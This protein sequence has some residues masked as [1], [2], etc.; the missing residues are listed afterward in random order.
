MLLLPPPPLRLRRRHRPLPVFIPCAGSNTCRVLD[1]HIY[2]GKHFKDGARVIDCSTLNL[3]ILGPPDLSGF[4]AQEIASLRLN[5]ILT[6]PVTDPATG[7]TT[8]HLEEYGSISAPS[9]PMDLYYGTKRRQLKIRSWR[10]SV[11]SSLSLDF[12]KTITAESQD[13]HLPAIVAADG[14]IPAGPSFSRSSSPRP[15]SIQERQ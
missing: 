3:L 14:P 8:T 2:K 11:F 5:P 1:S 4:G 9:Q 6:I 15:M 10:Y 7:V 12:L 13:Y